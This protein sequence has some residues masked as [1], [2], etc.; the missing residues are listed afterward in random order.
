VYWDNEK[1]TRYAYSKLTSDEL[2]L[3]KD[4]KSSFNPGLVNSAQIT[5]D[6]VLEGPI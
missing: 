5:E 4:S 3:E 1:D 6:M 2:L